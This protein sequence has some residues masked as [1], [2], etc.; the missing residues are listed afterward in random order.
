MIIIYNITTQYAIIFCRRACSLMV[1]HISDKDETD[2]PILSSPTNIRIPIKSG[3][4]VVGTFK[5]KIYYVPHLRHGRL[6][7]L[8]ERCVYI[9]NVGG[10]S[11]SASTVLEIESDVGSSLAAPINSSIFKIVNIFEQIRTYF[12]E[13]C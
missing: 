3:F 8:V 7:Q 5:S 11:P 1:K 13:S 9:A 10:S 4:N 2:S 12:K 6:A